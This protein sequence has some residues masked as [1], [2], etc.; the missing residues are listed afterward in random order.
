LPCNVALPLTSIHV[1]GCPE[2]VVDGNVKGWPGT[3]P[4]PRLIVVTGPDP[5]FE[6]VGGAGGVPAGVTVSTSVLLSEPDAFAAPITMLYVPG[7]VTEPL[8]VGELKVNPAGRT[9]AVYDVGEFVAVMVYEKDDPAATVAVSGLDITG[10]APAGVTVRTSVLLSDPDAFVAPSAMLYVPGV[11]T[12]PLIVGEL[13]VSP[14]GRAVAV[15]D[16]GEFVAVMVYEKED[17]VTT[18]AVSGL[19]MTGAPPAGVTVRTSVLLSKP[20]A[21]AAPSAM[22]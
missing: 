14:T 2:A 9:V 15:N 13:K 10:A 1:I 18:D 4:S 12:E 6:S 8:M 19:D 7:A 11:A 5:L 22:L 16:V 17:P 3:R 21:F 20:A